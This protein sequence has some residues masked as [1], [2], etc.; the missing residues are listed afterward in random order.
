MATKLKITGTAIK[1]MAAG[2]TLR[3]TEMHGFLARKSA[4]GMVAFSAELTIRTTGRQVRQKIGD[5][6]SMSIPAA[7]ARVAKMRLENAA[8]HN[9]MQRAATPRQSNVVRVGDLVET[10]LRAIEAK[11]SQSTVTGYRGAMRRDVLSARIASVPTS[12]VTRQ[13][14][15]AV[16]DAAVARSASSGAL[17]FRTIQSFLSW[18]EDRGHIDIR[19]PRAKRVA[20]SVAARTTVITDAE[21]GALWHASET[22]TKVTKAAARL[23]WLTGLRSGAAQAVERD[24]INQSGLTVPAEAMKSGREFWVPLSDF[25]REQLEPVMGR[26][27][28]IFGVGGTRLNNALPKLRKRALGEASDIQWHDIRRSIRTFFAANGIDDS[29]AEA[30]LAH[31]VQKDQLAKAYQQYDFREEAGEALLAWQTHVERITA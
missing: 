29:A 1:A 20:P 3:D 26:A 4:D 10:W 16:I 17:T 27:G 8:G 2:E 9:P 24:W 28:R 11:L 15:M 12:S 25:T 21:L 5:F 31:T 14:F 19:L 18:C 22:C 6:R 23:I 13:D 30:A 7:R